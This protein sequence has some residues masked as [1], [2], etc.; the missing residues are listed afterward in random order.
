MWIKAETLYDNSARYVNLNSVVEIQLLSDNN[1][2]LKVSGGFQYYVSKAKNPEDY[3]NLMD[4][5]GSAPD[6]NHYSSRSYIGL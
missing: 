2:F 6:S 5:I 3:R 1:L 4:I